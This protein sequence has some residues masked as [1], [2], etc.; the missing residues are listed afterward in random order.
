MPRYV[1]LLRFTLQGVRNLKQSPA[2][3]AAFRKTAE[4]AGVK[5]EAQLWIA[6]N[7]DGILILNA[8]NETKALNAIAKLA[9]TGNVSTHTMQAF[10]ER[11]FATIVSR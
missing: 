2:R 5:V 8:A 10:D 4:R 7:Y 11:D 6:G 9:A 3:A 1:S